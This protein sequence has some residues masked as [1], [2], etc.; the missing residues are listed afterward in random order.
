MSVMLGSRVYYKENGP[1]DSGTIIDILL[2]EFP[3]VVKWDNQ[4]PSEFITVKFPPTKIAEH[5]GIPQVGIY[6]N[7]A[8]ENIDQ[9]CGS[10]LALLEDER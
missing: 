3:F 9:F 10:Q 5:F 2:D 1:E 4:H 8:D 7:P 6:V